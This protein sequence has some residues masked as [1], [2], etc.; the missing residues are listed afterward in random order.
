MAS[1]GPATHGRCLSVHQ[2]SQATTRDLVAQQD[3]PPL[4]SAAGP[5]KVPRGDITSSPLTQSTGP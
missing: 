4:A 2:A 5:Q 3:D 1:T